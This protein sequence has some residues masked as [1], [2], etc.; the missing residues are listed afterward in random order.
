MPA[1]RCHHPIG[2]RG[3]RARCRPVLVA[4][5]TATALVTLRCSTQGEGPGAR[6][7][8]RAIPLVTVEASGD[9]ADLRALAPVIGDARVVALG[10]PVHGAHEPLAFRNRL[11]RYLV[12]ELGFTAIAIESG[13]PESRR[14]HDV[15]NGAPG[16]IDEAVRQG[17]TWGFGGFGENAALVRWMREYNASA[18][19]RRTIRFYGMDLS[20][21]GPLGSTPTT[22]PIEAAL[23]YLARV[24]P[25]SAA[26]SRAAFLP[27]LPK[28]PHGPPF[29]AAEHD[30]LTAAITGM[31]AL[32]DRNRAAYV[33]SS[34]EEDYDW[35]RQNA[36]AARQADR[37][38]RALPRDASGGGMPPAAWRALAARDAAMAENVRWILAREGPDARLLVFAHNA[39]VKNAPT[40]GG[41]WSVLDEPPTVMG[42]RL[43]AALGG[44]LLVVGASAARDQ[45]GRRALSPRSD[46][47][48]ARLA[49]FGRP[50]FLLDLRPARGDPASAWL[51]RPTTM[52]ANYD[53]FL[54]VTPGGA[55]DALLFIDALSPSRRETPGP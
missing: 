43:R 7:S 25:V 29:T 27:H 12:E 11:F 47:I 53:T 52:G 49:R 44:D 38:F 9:L 21:A 42:Q 48:D 18:S 31:A 32:F 45:G 33:A 50:L 6:A 10:E 41:V 24:D 19:R 5:V 46:S 3:S 2:C 54:T 22:A 4:A 26:R 17:L 40:E 34:S 8:A 39:H 13:L 51:S 55:F 16:G 30:L 20:L 35:A 14:V 15:V 1:P 36:R 37:V 23:S 28:L